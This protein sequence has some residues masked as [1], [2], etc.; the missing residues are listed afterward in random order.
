MSRLGSESKGGRARTPAQP[1]P[2]VSPG[3][4]PGRPHP[5]PTCSHQDW[6]TELSS[7][8]PQ[9]CITGPTV[10]DG[11]GCCPHSTPWMGCTARQS[12]QRGPPTG[13]GLCRHTAGQMG[14][15]ARPGGRGGQVIP[16]PSGSLE[17]SGVPQA[18][19][20]P[21]G[22]TGNTSH[23]VLCLKATPSALSLL[24]R[25]VGRAPLWACYPYPLMHG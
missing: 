12:P 9:V 14:A 22:S 17:G 19:M 10:A 7:P 5:G 13:P 16:A 2:A 4:G 21:Q 3:G 8:G 18:A 1:R 23:Y 25:R 11:H 6:G 15:S 20:Q 24:L